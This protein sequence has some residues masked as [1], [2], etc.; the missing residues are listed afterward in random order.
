MTSLLKLTYLQFKLLLR[1]PV[2]L[3]FNLLFPLLLFFLYAG[4]F[5]GGKP[6]GVAYL[7]GP[8]ITL[9]FISNAIYGVGTQ[10]VVLRE[11]GALRHFQLAPAK[12]YQIIISRILGSYLM[13][14]VLTPL[15]LL[16]AV[17]F[18]H[19]PFR[20]SIGSLIVVLTAGYFAMAAVGMIIPSVVNSVEQ[21]QICNQLVFFPLI[22]LSGATISLSV[23]PKFLQT[24]AAFLP[25]TLLVSLLQNLFSKGEGLAG[26]Y[27]E[28]LFLLFILLVGIILSVKLFRWDHAHAI[29]PRDRVI[30]LL[31]VIP[32]V[33]S[34]LWLQRHMNVQKPNQVARNS[35]PNLVGR[36][37]TNF[38]MQDQY[39]KVFRLSDANAP[40]MVVSV[41]MAS[42]TE[43]GPWMN[44]IFSAPQIQ[45]VPR[46]PIIAIIVD[47]HTIPDSMRDSVLQQFQAKDSSGNP[48]KPVLMDWSGSFARQY[49]AAPGILDSYLLDS[50]KTIR[51]AHAGAL[52]EPG[53]Q[54]FY[55]VLQHI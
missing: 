32:F 43:L 11:R 44:K 46:I 41:D 42:V 12:P 13:Y 38:E 35:Q 14:V 54:E 25:S 18:F 51:Y 17:Y 37:M 53:L 21:A 28:V 47:L 27:L 50:G 33:F 29:Q 31:V 24:V 9:T 26:H 1:I 49:N 19:A 36:T 10:L 22:F 45:E 3:F 40:V 5:A 23:F 6:E 8:L 15:I 7:L 48:R 20:P 39:G 30:A 16:L 2:A 4:V 52:D 34:G 55:S